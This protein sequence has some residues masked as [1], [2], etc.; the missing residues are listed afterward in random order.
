MQYQALN[1]FNF[2]NNKFVQNNADQMG[3]AI[4]LDYSH[5]L[6]QLI[7]NLSSSETNITD[8]ENP[9]VYPNNSC[10]SGNNFT[11]NTAKF[12]GAAI[13]INGYNVSDISNNSF[14]GSCQNL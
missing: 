8:P 12:G 14:N 6:K 7:G 4:Y 13:T 5:A 10:L 3:G 1:P 2:S 9:R 11:H